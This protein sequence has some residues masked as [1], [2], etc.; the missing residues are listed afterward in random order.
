MPLSD[1]DICVARTQKMSAWIHRE[2]GR[3]GAVQ[4]RIYLEHPG[5]VV[6]LPYLEDGRMVLIENRRVVV[7]KTL[8]EVPAGTVVPGEDI[9]EAA[10]RELREETGV[11]G[12]EL[13]HLGNYFA[14]PAFCDE[15]L[16]VFAVRNGKIGRPQPDDVEHIVPVPLSE[17]TVDLY[18]DEGRIEDG[19]TLLALTYWRNQAHRIFHERDTA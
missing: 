3:S 17:D 18:L 16:H 19:K 9:F 8:L 7:G 11:E 2:Q 4:E 10:R 12:G 5:A 6:I 1:D 15:V 14:A 13:L